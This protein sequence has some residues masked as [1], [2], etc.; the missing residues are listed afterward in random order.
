MDYILML[1]V[2]VFS[3][4]NSALFRK[5]S[6]LNKD[7][8][9]SVY[10][11][12]AGGCVMWLLVLLPL[13]VMTGARFTTLSAVYGIIYGL[14]LFLY[15][16][17]NCKAI[18][19]GPV[20]ITMLFSC[21]SFIIATV[22]GIIYCNES[23]SIY[24]IV[25]MI[26]IVFAVILCLNPKY[27]GEKLTLKW[28]L[29]C[30]G[31]FLSNG[32]IGI[33]Y[34]LFGQVGSGDQ[35]DSMLITAAATAIVLYVITDLCGYKKSKKSFSLP[36]KKISI[37]IIAAGL[38]TCIFIRLNIYLANVI[39]SAV[40]FPVINGSVVVLSTVV[41]KF[42]FKEKLSK[43]QLWGIIIGLVAIVITGCLEDIIKLF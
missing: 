27:S 39:P 9:V 33:V 26:M 7:N 19:L 8:K 34:K 42:L 11:F 14:L 2:I 30:L 3:V 32:C 13:L 4:A 21:P 29:Y 22:F 6:E 41:G 40:F 17:C 31:F 35:Y 18:E 25:G 20:S 28:F 1:M 15:L 43:I 5:Y 16:M 10:T 12:N 38:M 37:L 36:S 23:V 24:Q